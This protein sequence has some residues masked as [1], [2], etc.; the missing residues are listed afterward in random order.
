MSLPTLPGARSMPPA[1][2]TMR[3]EHLLRE[4]RLD[5]GTS[6][7]RR[8]PRVAVAVALAALASA[9]AAAAALGVVSR[10]ERLFNNGPGVVVPAG[11]PNFGGINFSQATKLVSLTLGSGQVVS[12]WQ[13]PAVN[14][15]GVCTFEAYSAPASADALPTQASSAK[16]NT[17]PTPSRWP[18]PGHPIETWI[19]GTYDASTNSYRMLLGGHVDPA[20]GIS[21][22]ELQTPSGTTAL[23][24][25]SGYY[26]GELANSPSADSL[27]AGGPYKLIGLDSAGRKVA[28]VS[29]EEVVRLASPS[30]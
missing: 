14:G 6:G 25:A 24:F 29:L 20:S 5:T 22:I 18:S 2:L 3:R 16:C 30:H 8:R 4:L 28:N 7:R 11:V 19:Q 23:P 1:H 27:P 26:L 21:Q 13:A 9:V 17:T 15:N 10:V 12:T